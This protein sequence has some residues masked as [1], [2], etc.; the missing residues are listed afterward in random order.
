MRLGQLSLCSILLA[1]L[2]A[3]PLSAQVT[4]QGQAV[5]EGTE[6]LITCELT[7][8]PRLSDVPVLN[9]VSEARKALGT[10]H[11]KLWVPP[12]YSASAT[13]RWPCI[14]IQ[15][16]GG[17]AGMGKMRDC[18]VS[19]QFVVVML[20]E[21]KNGDWGPAIG[22]S[23]AAHDDVIKRL[24]IQEG[25]KYATGFSGGARAASM[26]VQ[27]RSG[28]CGLILQ[29]AGAAYLDSGPYVVAGLKRSPGLF[30][31]MAVGKADSNKSEVDRMKNLLPAHRLAIFDFEGGHDWTPADT[32][33]KAF[34]WIKSKVEKSPASQAGSASGSSFD[35]FFKKK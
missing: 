18:L 2:W 7:Q 23:L 17:N 11:Y 33:G 29:G 4:P 31:A 5:P 9:S 10:Y 25:R 32:F 35:N 16:P 30:V 21:S 6:T 12:G 1:T 3:G 13:K 26:L 28:F 22:N 27:A 24:R 34:D 14:F 15:S 19:N 20:V 8:P